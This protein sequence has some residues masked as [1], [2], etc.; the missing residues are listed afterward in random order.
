MLIS[1]GFYFA[2]ESADHLSIESLLIKLYYLQ[3]G[4]INKMNIHVK[5]L[6]N[7][8]IVHFNICDY[9]CMRWLYY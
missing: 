1:V 7:E 9:N 8:F 4:L 3:K 6:F 2:L 5:I